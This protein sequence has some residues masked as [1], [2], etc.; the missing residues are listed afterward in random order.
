MNVDANQQTP[1]EPPEILKE[2]GDAAVAGNDTKKRP[3]A[4]DPGN[5]K[6]DARQATKREHYYKTVFGGTGDHSTT[7]I[8][9]A[10]TQER[11]EEILHHSDIIP[12]HVAYPNKDDVNRFAQALVKQHLLRVTYTRRAREDMQ[13]ALYSLL[14]HLRDTHSHLRRFTSN[15]LKPPELKLFT[16]HE[17]GWV[18]T[19]GDSIIYLDLLDY[20][21]NLTLS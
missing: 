15:N 14:E 17:K 1:E 4:S 19:L 5:A 16:N 11:L 12:P 9:F 21:D 7:N 13:S 3:E 8:H 2:A 10:K 20:P 18:E 6:L